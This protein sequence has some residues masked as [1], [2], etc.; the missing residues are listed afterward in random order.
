MS[1]VAALGR[2]S[3]GLLWF[4][5]YGQPG[6]LAAVVDN[7]PLFVKP[8][9]PDKAKTRQRVGLRLPYVHP[10]LEPARL[11]GGETWNAA[12]WMGDDYAAFSFIAGRSRQCGG[13]VRVGPKYLLTTSQRSATLALVRRMAGGT[14]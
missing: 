11:S 8:I 9:I 6:A 10:P 5:V 4:E 12:Y 1:A 13:P 14:T 3:A 7:E 2:S